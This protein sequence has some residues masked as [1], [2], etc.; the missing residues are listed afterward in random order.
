MHLGA[1]VG[2]DN[3]QQVTDRHVVHVVRLLHPLIIATR[4]PIRMQ[5]DQ[6]TCTLALRDDDGFIRCQP[7]AYGSP[8]ER[9]APSYEAFLPFGLGGRP[10]PPTKGIGAHVLVMRQG[11]DTMAL[12]GHDPRWM[13]ARPDFGDGGAP[14]VACTGTADAPTAPY[15]A[16][17]GEGAAGGEAEGLFR[18]LAKTT[19]G[20]AKIEIAP[21]TG[22]V[23]ITHPSGTVVVVKSSGVELGAASGGVPL[24]KETGALA[25]FFAAV[26]SAL[27]T[28]GQTVTAPAGY[29]CSKVNGT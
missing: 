4:G 24:V 15:V 26:V 1:L 14:L 5:F 19:A 11:D 8:G 9:S 6:S 23:T 20:D 7:E 17:F 10:K 3:P 12:P 28:L 29:T 27:G 25:T 13:S 16:F 18:I 21:S 2:F 22:D